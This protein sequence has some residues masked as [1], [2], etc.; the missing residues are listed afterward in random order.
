MQKST[1]LKGRPRTTRS[2]QRLA[3]VISS[4]SSAAAREEGDQPV[5][6]AHVT[7]SL[8]LGLEPG[9]AQEQADGAARIGAEAIEH[10]ARIQL[11]K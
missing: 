10:E 9:V 5:V 1:A 6:L 7:V 11:G 3:S 4:I 2:C 8:L